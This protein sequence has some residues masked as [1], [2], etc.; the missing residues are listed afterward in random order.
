[1]KDMFCFQCQQTAHNTG[2]DGKVGVCGK[3]A[4]TAVYQDELI[5]ALIALANAAE[6]G[7]STEKTDMLILKGLF[8]TITNVN[9]NKCEILVI[10]LDKCNY[11]C[12][13]MFIIRFMLNEILFLCFK[14]I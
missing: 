3:K 5:G 4:D 9:F 13:N 8:T 11:V 1:M 6:N 12:Y 2:C 10:T 14:L 7:S